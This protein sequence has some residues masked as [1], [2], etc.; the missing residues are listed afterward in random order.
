MK[1][2]IFTRALLPALRIKNKGPPATRTTFSILAHL[3]RPD[4]LRPIHAPGLSSS[5]NTCSFK[6]GPLERAI[7][8]RPKWVRS[9]TCEC[10]KHGVV[11]G[12]VPIWGKWNPQTHISGSLLCDLLSHSEEVISKSPRHQGSMSGWSLRAVFA[13]RAN[14][15]LSHPDCQKEQ[16]E[17]VKGGE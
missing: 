17:L 8:L 1:L 9:Q 6:Q 7:C 4:V 13:P 5:E 10:W 16:S 12:G 3:R 14:K 11:V 2:S 15:N